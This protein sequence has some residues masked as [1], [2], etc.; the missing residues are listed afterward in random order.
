MLLITRREGEAIQIHCGEHILEVTVTMMKGG[1]VRLGCTGSKDMR[2]IR[3]ELADRPAAMAH[4][5][6]DR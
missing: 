4:F 6:A 5:L 3:K 2:V 1:Q